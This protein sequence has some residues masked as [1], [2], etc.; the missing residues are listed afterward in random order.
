MHQRGWKNEPL[1]PCC[2]ETCLARSLLN[3][4]L[5]VEIWDNH[6]E[7]A[8]QLWNRVF[9]FNQIGVFV[10]LRTVRNHIDRGSSRDSTVRH[11][12]KICTRAC[13]SILRV[14][15]P[16]MQ[17]VSVAVIAVC[18]LIVYMFIAFTQHKLDDKS[19]V[20]QCKSQHCLPLSIKPFSMVIVTLRL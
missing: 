12:P 14:L 10:N 18:D 2:N 1:I 20:I 6:I 17:C 16:Y 4:C 8:C 5:F 7:S 19:L 13:G 3:R 9:L 15:H 11:G